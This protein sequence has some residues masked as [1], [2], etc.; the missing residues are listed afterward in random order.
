MGEVYRALDT[1]VGRQVALKIL[2]ES[3]ARDEERR[4]RFE[5]EARLAASLNHPNLMAI[6]DVGLD[7]HPPYI[8]SEFVPGESLRA[9]VAKGPLPPRRALD[10]AAQM[11]AGLAAAHAAGIVHRD[12]K[13][14]N[15]IVTP[16]GTAKILDFGIA[17]LHSKVTAT[18]ATLTATMSQTAAGS[19]VGTAAYMSP[20]QARAE[21]VDWRSDQFSLGL[22]LYEML[23]GKQPFARA[24]A[25]QTMSA[26]VE[27]EPPPLE[28][29]VPPQVRWVLERCL[30]KE[31]SGRYDSTSDLARELG[32][33]RD[34]YSELTSAT[35]QVT[36]VTPARRSR[37]LAIAL[38]TLV[39]GALAATLFF[40]LT[41][42]RT[43]V[44]LSDYHLTPFATALA[45]QTGPSWSPDGKSIAFRGQSDTGKW[46]LLVQTLTAPT[47]VSLTAPDVVVIPRAPPFWSSDSRFVYFNCASGGR[48]G[49]C[50]VPAGGG[51]TTMVQADVYCATISPDGRTLAMLDRDEPVVYTATPPEAQ[52]RKYEPAPIPKG[53]FYNS[54]LIAF[55]PDGKQILLT[56]ALTGSGETAWLLPWPAGPARRIVSEFGR[57]RFT[58]QFSW[59][60]DSRHIV[61]SGSFNGASAELLLADTRSGKMWPVLTQDR[62]VS[63]PTVSPDGRRIAYQ[64]GLSQTDVIAVPL[65][66]GPVETVLGSF[67]DEDMADA[68]PAT[69]QIAYITN[70]R[71][72]NEL[73][74]ASTS[75]GTQRPLLTAQDFGGQNDSAEF[76]MSPA[77]SRDG[78]RIAT[79]G[80]VHGSTYVYTLFAAGGSPVRATHETGVLEFA[81]TWSPDGNWLAYVRFQS[82]TDAL[83]K[84]RPG[85]GD[86]PVRISAHNTSSVPVWSPTGEWIADYDEH[87]HPLLIS[88]DGAKTKVLPGDQGPVVWSR[89]GKTL[90][91]VREQPTALY[92]IDIAAGKDRKIR[93][94]PGLV[95]TARLNPGIKASLSQDGKSII[96]TVNR[97][98][99]EIWLLDGVKAP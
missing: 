66:D 50:R 26:I 99:Q 53:T 57:L 90:Y 52:R 27:D 22:V 49:I 40:T 58:P 13:P 89:D 43:Q 81:P 96:Y 71:G 80:S 11:A 35:G 1:R 74:I 24:S 62:P 28:R 59:L 69:S 88:P 18:N 20:E 75:E 79:C 55:A 14:E 3:P 77:F 76:F 12:L 9:M 85:S 54:P 65:A 44:Q 67:R 97:A 84:I 36:A 70:R 60:P 19:V 5:Q 23:S 8:V 33:L 51:E 61:F 34:R 21:D 72:P 86:P 93:D 95:P 6:Y 42:D 91:Q 47:A 10:I 2:P 29:P 37:T 63:N 64:S 38:G 7:S 39:L 68:S 87:D 56:L 73:W 46:Q 31:R 15:I 17:R 78:R 83:M 32:H 94:L 4:R 16:E 92:A 82:G 25:V 98:R 48:D 41:R 45:V 30:A